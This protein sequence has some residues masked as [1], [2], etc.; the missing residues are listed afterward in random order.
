MFFTA[1]MKAAGDGIAIP[2]TVSPSNWNSSSA[3]SKFIISSLTL[4]ALVLGTAFG[5]HWQDP[6]VT[7]VVALSSWKLRI[8]NSVAVTWW[9]QPS[10]LKADILQGGELIS[11]PRQQCRLAH[12]RYCWANV[13]STYIA[14]WL[15][16]YYH[17]IEHIQC[18]ILD[19]IVIIF[20][21]GHVTLMVITVTTILVPH[22]MIF[23]SSHCNSFACLWPLQCI[24]GSPILKQKWLDHMRGYQESSPSSGCQVICP[25][26]T[27]HLFQ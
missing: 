6:D 16:D 5:S 24:Y 20:T 15:V 19:H 2:W 13:R 12:R 10:I 22:L 9:Q 18:I 26:V 8:S 14:V 23:N 3:F 4:T 21:T 1:S 11:I 17:N 7:L 25:A 27:K